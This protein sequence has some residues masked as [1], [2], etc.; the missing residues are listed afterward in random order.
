MARFNAN[1]K[2]IQNINKMIVDTDKYKITNHKGEQVEITGAELKK[3]MLVMRNVVDF[4]HL[5]EEIA[6]AKEDDV[7]TEQKSEEEKPTTSKTKTP[8][9]TAETAEDKTDKTEQPGI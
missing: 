9:N 8:K 7:A 4:T 1:S 3:Y 6:S 5:E 2:K